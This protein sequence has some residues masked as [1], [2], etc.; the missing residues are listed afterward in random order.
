MFECWNDGLEGLGGLGGLEGKG[1]MYEGEGERC[2]F[3]NSNSK[4]ELLTP[5]P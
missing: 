3:S 5:N 2:P 1:K 4:L